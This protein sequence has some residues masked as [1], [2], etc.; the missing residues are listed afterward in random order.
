[1]VPDRRYRKPPVIEALCEIYFAESAWDD[2]IPGVFYEHIKN[3]FPRKQ[4]REIQ[5]AEITLGTIEAKAGVRHLPPW[6]QFISDDKHRMIQIAKDL[7]VVNQLHPY[8]HF[9]EWEPETYRA[10]GIYR[11]LTQFQRV[12]RFGLRY[13]NR[14][15]IPGDR[16]R[17]EDYFMIYPSLPT[18]I[19][20]AHGSFLVRVEVPQVEQKHNL[21]ITFGTAPQQQTEPH[22]QVFMLDLYNI[23]QIEKSLAEFD[24]RDEIQGAHDN[25]VTA[26][27][28]SITDRLRDIFEPEKDQT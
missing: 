1:M 10:V 7:L 11:E 28:G 9:E 27:E 17:M 15:V 5:E 22:A 25:I 23:V 13:L 4:Q 14:V 16:I 20:D 12:S 6:M 18:G 2:T 26:F 19:G 3:D 21:L 24:L 8:P